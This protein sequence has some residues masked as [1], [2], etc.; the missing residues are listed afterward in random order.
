MI[1]V[2]VVTRHAANAVAE[3]CKMVSHPSKC[4]LTYGHN[5]KGKGHHVASRVWTHPV[6]CRVRWK[7]EGVPK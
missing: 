1:C 6:F 5:C 2:L 4:I 7:L 3:L